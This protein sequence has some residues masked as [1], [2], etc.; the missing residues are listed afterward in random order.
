M[1]KKKKKKI[2]ATEIK[3]R[4]QIYYLNKQK[5]KVDE[6]IKAIEHLKDTTKREYNGRKR[7]VKTIKNLLKN[8]KVALNT[9]Y[10]EV[11]NSLKKRFKYDYQ[12]KKKRETNK[13][14]TYISP[15]FSAFE[16]KDAKLDASQEIPNEFIYKAFTEI[17]KIISLMTS[18]DVFIFSF[19]FGAYNDN[20][21][22][23][24][25]NDFNLLFKCHIV[26]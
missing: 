18:G 15:E 24:I 10:K 11:L 19:N 14:G 16:G 23:E 3:L 13:I 4:N 25:K 22:A 2:S 26:G 5:K 12:G 8:R 7:M 17:D 9:K 20:L 1:A 6:Q 21:E